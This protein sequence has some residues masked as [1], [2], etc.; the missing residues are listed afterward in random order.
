MFKS[1][2]QLQLDD[3]WLSDEHQSLE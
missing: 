2:I 1:Y 3:K